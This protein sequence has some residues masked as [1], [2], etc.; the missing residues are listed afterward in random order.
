M[1]DKEAEIRRL[2]AEIEA[3]KEPD[4]VIYP[5][6]VEGNLPDWAKATEK[7]QHDVI[8][9]DFEDE[10]LDIGYVRKP[11]G[12]SMDNWKDG[13]NHIAL[14]E[15]NLE[16][17][18]LEGKRGS[19]AVSGQMIQDIYITGYMCRVIKSLDGEEMDPVKIKTKL[20]EELG[21][22]LRV[23]GKCKLEHRPFPKPAWVLL[24][25]KRVEEYE[26]KKK[27]MEVRLKGLVEDPSRPSGSMVPE[28]SEEFAELS[29]ENGPKT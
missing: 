13:Q 23:W 10:F 9:T 16:K 8:P 26:K 2:Q 18:Q 21:A 4:H 7:I 14:I 29:L 11:L 3:L 19:M 15:G 1:Q 22:T 24:R 17:K 28:G 6:K 20:S 12:S 5:E 27:E 25:E